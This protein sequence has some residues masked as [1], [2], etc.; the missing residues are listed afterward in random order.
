M[1]ETNTLPFERL[2][3][4]NYQAFTED[5]LNNAITDLIESMESYNAGALLFVSG[6]MPR[7]CVQKGA[8]IDVPGTEPIA[9][10][11]LIEDMGSLGIVYNSCT[12]EYAYR[13]QAG[14][15]AE[16]RFFVDTFAQAGVFSVTLII[17][18]K[19]VR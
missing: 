6:Y 14:Y 8:L 15:Y 2:E 17:T 4:P 16:I 18:G 11:E 10:E 12:Y 1:A 3:D 7:Y 5:G 9:Y 13:P 19:T